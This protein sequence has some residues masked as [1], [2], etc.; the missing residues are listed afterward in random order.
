MD[1]SHSRMPYLGTQNSFN[2]PLKQH[3]QGVLVHGVGK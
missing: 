3:I 2:K 1:Q